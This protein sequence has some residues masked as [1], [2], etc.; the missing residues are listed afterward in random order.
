MKILVI[1]GTGKVGSAVVAGLRDL[2][3]DAMA[4]ARTNAPG[5]LALD[6]MQPGSVQTLAKGFDTAFLIT[7]LVPNEAEIGIRAIDELRAAG[8]KK[9]V[10][11]GIHNL[12]EMAQI[13]HFASKIPIRDHL[14]ADGVS[15]MLA[16]NF[17]FQNDLN[18]MG[19]IKGAGVYPMPVGS[20]G[21]Y[22]IDCRDIA[23]AG[24]R[25]LT[26]DHWNATSQPLCGSAKLTGPIMAATWSRATGRPVIYPGDD[27]GPFIDGL[28]AAMPGFDAWIEHDMRTMMDV[29]QA[30][31]CQASAH[32]IAA[33][34]EIIGKPQR[35]Y[36]DFVSEHA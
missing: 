5:V 20:A 30:M 33:S 27:T 19:A 34:K 23:R 8:V 13:P 32:D 24:V 4:A 17:F 3:H 35:P 31:G 25:A 22:S 29:T 9:T 26:M 15:V 16:A 7:P 12:D 18:I 21:V 10:Y 6:L 2:G 14:L 1:G 11:L 28:R 36:E